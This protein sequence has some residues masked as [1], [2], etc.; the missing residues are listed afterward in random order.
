M[1]TTD[2]QRDC[3][4][5]QVR[6]G[7]ADLELSRELVDFIGKSPTAY[8]AV[9]EM[10]ARLDAAGFSFLPESGVWEL[11]RGGRY[12]TTRN[13]SSLIAFRVGEELSDLR[14]QIAASHSDSPTFKVKAKAE[15]K[16][17]GPYVRLNVE[18]YGGTIDRTWLDRPLT[19]A[20]RVVLREDD[21]LRSCLVCFDRD[22]LIIPSVAVH[23]NREVNDEGAI[24][25]RSDIRPLF[26]GGAEGGVT[27]VDEL[28]ARELGVEPEQI[29]MRDLMLINR[30]PGVVWGAASEFV[31]APRLD[32]LQCAFASLRAFL[33]AQNEDAVTVFACF[34]NEEVGSGTAQ[35]ALSTFLQDVLVRLS[36]QLGAGAQAFRQAIARSFMVSCDNAHAVH[37]NHP[38]L[39][40]DTNQ[41]WMNRGVVLKEAANQ[42]YAGDGFAKAL[43]EEVCRRA[44]VP[45]QHFANRSDKPGGSTLGNLATRNVS[46]RV[47][48]VGLPQLAMHSSYETAGVLDTGYLARALAAFYSMRYEQLGDGSLQLG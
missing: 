14:F 37:P 10:R 34:D 40:D 1:K 35:G 42:R 27:T 33:S 36:E 47:V 46:L 26:L 19:L 20:G 48:D 7:E 43:F 9:R 11:A 5:P 6:I 29:L 18:A 13:D 12:Y 2:E 17:P 23:L 4:A 31:S 21:A 3:G 24:D 16:G 8:H 32:D 25:R 39:Y 41:T 30:Q 44:E 15:A 22:L 38:E 28:V 45:L